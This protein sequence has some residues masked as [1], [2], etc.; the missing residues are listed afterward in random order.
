M[1]EELA[2]IR[3]KLNSRGQIQIE[4]KEEMKRR[5]G[6]S[7]DRA[8]ML[9]MLVDSSSDTL[10]MWEPR[11]EREPSVAALLRAEMTRWSRCS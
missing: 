2:S 7:P 9:A 3:W 5:L 8:D 1:A 10:A 11:R 4:S 6:R